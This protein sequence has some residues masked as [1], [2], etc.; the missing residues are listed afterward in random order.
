MKIFFIYI[1]LCLIWGSTWLVIRIGL[2]DLTPLFSAAIRFAVAAAFIL[3]LM[4][5]RQIKLQTDK[6]SVRL[7]IL[8]GTLSLAL[9]FFFIYWAEQFVPS[10][11]AA[12]LF[13]VYPFFIALFSYLYISKDQIDIYKA[14]GMVLAFVGI[15]IIFSDE[16]GKDLS[17]YLIGMSAIVIAAVIQ[18]SMAV[19]IKKFGNHLNPLSINLVPMTIA[20]AVL[21]LAAFLFE[22]FSKQTF[23]GSAAAS[24][25]YLAFFG[26]V[27]T[28]TGYYYLLKRI[29]IV[30]LSLIT[31][32]TPIIAL[33]LGWIFYN[34]QLSN[35]DFWGSMLVLTGLLAANMKGLIMLRKRKILHQE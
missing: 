13:A 6:I 31:F 22:D 24:I 30:I 8:I 11:L 5:L 29:N 16:F 32:V 23:T 3:I 34:E 14:A 18:A 2:E 4:N 26:S 9:P 20:A 15:L 35:K 21:F 25:L 19:T 28:F 33:L 17:L 12:V 1:S 10:G 27:V 7:Y